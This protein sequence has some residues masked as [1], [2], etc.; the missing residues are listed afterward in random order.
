LTL[1]RGALVR[2]TVTD[3][4]TGKPIAG[5]MAMAVVT[6]EG[7][8]SSNAPQVTTADDGT[9]TVIVSPA[10]HG[11]VLVKGPNNDY[12]ATEIT[13]GEMNGG[14]RYGYRSYPD[15]IIPFEA[16]AASST[17]DVAA[18]LHRGVTIRGKLLGPDDKP[19]ADALMSCWSQHHRGGLEWG[20][21][22]SASVPL[23]DGAFEL[24]GCDP[25]VT[26]PVYFLDAKNKL[27]ATVQLSAKEVAGKEVTV[28]LEPCGSAVVRCLDKDGKPRKGARPP[29]YMVARPGNNRP[30]DQ[31]VFPDFDFLANVDTVS[32]SGW[33]PT[34][35]AEGRLTLPVLIPGA[36]YGIAIKELQSNF[37]ELTVKPGEKL[38]MDIVIEPQQ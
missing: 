31:N 8:G 26:Y 4:D 25:E 24:R 36:T 13:T 23:R 14:K 3:A 15:A 21:L 11:Q 18:K 34:A 17:V 2:G 10:R 5:A 27:G 30:G 29:T 12:V 7:F 9:F 38:K 37:K 35:D 19:V 6:G 33:D 16:K 20:V 32:Y 22:S 1:A 28:R